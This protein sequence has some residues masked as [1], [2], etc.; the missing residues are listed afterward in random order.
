MDFAILD[1]EHGPITTQA[2]Q[3]NIRVAEIS[4]MISV[5][6]VPSVSEESIRKGLDTGAN[7]IQVPKTRAVSGQTQ[8]TR[9]KWH[10]SVPFLM[11]QNRSF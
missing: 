10:F 9:R 5:V 6:R 3:N 4:G 7:A 1:M 2:M 11:Y 8:K